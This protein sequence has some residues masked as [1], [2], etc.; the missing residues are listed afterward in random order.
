MKR[1]V[2][3][4]E[5]LFDEAIGYLPVIQDLVAE[6]VKH[7]LGPQGAEGES[8]R[9]LLQKPS[10]GDDT[11]TFVVTE[12]LLH[13]MGFSSAEYARLEARV[14]TAARV[15]RRLEELVTKKSR[16]PTDGR[17]SGVTLRLVSVHVFLGNGYLGR[18]LA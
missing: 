9:K 2:E 18:F 15:V 10:S 6:V 17:A 11:P 16:A 1:Y 14:Q 8:R 13:A 5:A 4:G 12:E 3:M 7:S